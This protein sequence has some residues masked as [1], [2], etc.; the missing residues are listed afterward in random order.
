MT[1]VSTR[2]AAWLVAAALLLPAGGRAAAAPG[3]AGPPNVVLIY[4][5][6]QG[7]ADVGCYGAKAI[8]TPNLDRLAADG[9][10]FTDFYV[11]QPVCSASRA[12]L[13]TGCYPNRLGIHGALAPGS[14]AGLADTETTLARLLKAKGYATGMVGKWH[15]GDR[16]PF[17]PPRHGFDT[18]LGLPYSNDMW[19]GHPEA[20]AGTYPPLPLHDGDAVANPNVSA[21]DQATLTA[22]YTERAVAFIAANKAKPFFLYVAHAMPHVPLFAGDRFKGK[23]A[24]GRYGDVIEEV[25]WSVGEVLKAL[26]A[27]GVAG[28]TLVLFA[29]DN[30]PWLS[31][32][33]HGGSAGPLREGK[34][35]TWEGGVRVPFVARW[36]GVVPPGT[37]CREPAMTID[38]LPTVA[39]AVG[40]DLPKGPL[41]GK[42]IGPLLRGEP[43]AKSPHE[44]LYFYYQTNALEAVRA[45]DWKLV[46]PHAYR[47][48]AGQ[49]PG[50]GGVPGRYRQARVAAPE[51]YNLAADPGEARDVTAA[52]PDAVRRL[53][54]HAEAA[55]A[56]LGDSL[57]GRKGTGL[58]EPGRAPAGEK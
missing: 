16:R 32:G 44:A 6:D 30:G 2:P 39:K 47:T 26:A 3:G 33:D 22:K 31:Y 34:G 41:D 8:R 13:L 12:S 11:A 37:V 18:W 15:L 21:A 48:M 40:A 57:T 19:P 54:A 1:I 49:T 58:R 43:G 45:G 7:Y 9:V 36:P 52:N 46:L 27:H 14:R 4:T 50:A 53:L 29:S 24:G 51:L 25:D 17:L 38:V 23:S 42:D 56:D 10:R 28:N 35:T 5:D 55:R 20:K